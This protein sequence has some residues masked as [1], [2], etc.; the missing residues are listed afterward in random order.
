MR[1]HPRRARATSP[2]HHHPR[3]CACTCIPPQPGHHTAPHSVPHRTPRQ[4]ASRTPNP[5]PD[6][7]PYLGSWREASRRVSAA[8]AWARY[9]LLCGRGTWSAAL[10][11]SIDSPWPVYTGR[12]LRGGL[13]APV[14]CR[15][16]FVSCVCVCATVWFMSV[17]PAPPP[18]ATGYFTQ[19]GQ[20]HDRL[21]KRKSDR[22]GA[23]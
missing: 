4:L 7:Y 18:S 5:N 2:T 17:P 10:Q 1:R 6:P 20:P 19:G 16:A 11:L 3:P 15:A 23:M 14:R 9:W 21:P 22:C 12:Q 8:A 13:R